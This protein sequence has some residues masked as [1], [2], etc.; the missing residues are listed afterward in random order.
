MRMHFQVCKPVGK[1]KKKKEKKL[2][3]EINVSWWKSKGSG[4][5]NITVFTIKDLL[6]N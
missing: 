3:R 5:K 4:L 2:Q 1:E 6:E